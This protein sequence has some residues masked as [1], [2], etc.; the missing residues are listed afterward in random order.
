MSA[1]I[2]DRFYG[3]IVRLAVIAFIPFVAHE[4]FPYLKN[5]LI[6]V[7]CLLAIIIVFFLLLLKS[8]KHLIKLI[9]KLLFFLSESR[10][11]QIL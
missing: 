11:Q 1:M 7:S 2:V 10:T 9:D 3:I 4:M 8:T 6:Y 5:Y